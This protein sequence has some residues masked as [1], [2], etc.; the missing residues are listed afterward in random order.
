MDLKMSLTSL[1]RIECN[2][3]EEG[4]GEVKKRICPG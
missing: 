3:I 2:D 1:D 4:K